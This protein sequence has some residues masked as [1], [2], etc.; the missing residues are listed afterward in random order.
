MKS[1]I[2]YGGTSLL[3]IEFMKKYKHEVD[4]FIVITRNKKILMKK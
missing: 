4:K 2:I 3:S 1:I